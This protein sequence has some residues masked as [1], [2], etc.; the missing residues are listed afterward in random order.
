MST[1]PQNKYSKTVFRKVYNDKRWHRLRTMRMS[2]N[3]FCAVC[4]E[5]GFDNIPA[6]QVDHIIP[7]STGVNPFKYDNTQSICDVCHHNK[8]KQE[9]KRYVK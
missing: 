8:T 6:T 5:K 1:K 4:E 2:N 3:P 9:L 7:L